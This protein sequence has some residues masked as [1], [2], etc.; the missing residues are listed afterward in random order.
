MDGKWKKGVVVC[1]QHGTVI[2]WDAK[3]ICHC[4]SMPTF[5]YKNGK[6]VSHSHGTYFGVNKRVARTL[7]RKRNK[8]AETIDE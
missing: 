5:K 6:Q 4:T 3:L 1:L 8:A 7:K 2:T